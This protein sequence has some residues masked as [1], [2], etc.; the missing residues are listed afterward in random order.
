M[1]LWTGWALDGRYY[2][3]KTYR[4]HR[5]ARDIGS[6]PRRQPQH[7]PHFLNPD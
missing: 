2:N 1:S 5:D 3:G 7:S 6:A 4:E